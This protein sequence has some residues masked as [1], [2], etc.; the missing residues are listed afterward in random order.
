MH[1]K[2][3]QT[4][5][6]KAITKKRKLKSECPMGD[7]KEMKSRYM[8]NSNLNQQNH[9]IFTASCFLIKEEQKTAKRKL[10]HQ[11]MFGNGKYV[12]K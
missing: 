6:T 11:F 2:K 12:G 9:K 7:K 10:F 5:H 4:H 3:R 1:M 8:K